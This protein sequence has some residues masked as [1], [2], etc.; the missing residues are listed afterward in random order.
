MSRAKVVVTDYVTEPAAEGPILAPHAELL[1]ANTTRDVDLL[2]KFADA[3][4][5]LVFHDIVLTGQTLSKFP[6]LRGIVRCGV[7][8]DNVDLPA[9]G[10]LGIV[11]CNVPDY[12]TEDVADHSLMMLLA[13]ARRLKR[14]D[15]AIRQG[16]WDAT[17]IYGAPRLRGKTLGIIGCG[18]I[19]S[20]MALRGKALGMRVLIYD[21][22]QPPGYE[23]ALGVERAYTL[24]E[25]LPQ[26]GFVSIHT[27][28]TPETRHIINAESLAK[29]PRGAYIVNTARGPCVDGKALM[30][31]ID[32]GHL[33]AAALDVLEREPLDDERIRQDPRVLLT[34]HS[35][36]YSVEGFIEM[37]RK[38]GEEILRILTDEPVRN[39]VNRRWLCNPRCRLPAV[40]E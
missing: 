32:A 14:Q 3:D 1:F 7:G 27:P 35:A 19:G 8:Y 6:K 10:A 21:P 11:V 15:D 28:S 25:L 23:K 37:R 40:K 4:V 9:A 2:P 26:A 33:A 34:P 20:A 17:L 22:Y 38:A 13:I 39:P 29:L 31:A 30:D 16:I 18:R 12:G 24:D 36:F 5:F